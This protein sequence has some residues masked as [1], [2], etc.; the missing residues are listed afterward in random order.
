MA[1]NLDI[2]TPPTTNRKS[3]VKTNNTEKKESGAVLDLNFKVSA[4]F[5]R[6][7]KLWA[8]SHDV[9]QKRVL[10]LAFESLKEHQI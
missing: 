8:V 7:F 10:E 6:E 1:K 4:D 3:S 9:T 5:K 2:G